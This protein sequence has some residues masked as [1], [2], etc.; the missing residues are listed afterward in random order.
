VYDLR[1]HQ[2]KDDEVEVLVFF[3]ELVAGNHAI[4]SGSDIVLTER[5]NVDES[6]TLKSIV[7]SKQYFHFLYFIVCQK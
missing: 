6:K 2:V 1:H 7:F 3:E 4:L 5:E